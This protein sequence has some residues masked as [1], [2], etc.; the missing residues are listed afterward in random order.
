M[1]IEK[2]AL[3]VEESSD[4]DETSREATPPLEDLKP[5]NE[6]ATESVQETLSLIPVPAE[7]GTNQS[8]VQAIKLPPAPDPLIELVSGTSTPITTPPPIDITD[9][10]N[11]IIDIDDSIQELI[12]LTDDLE[13]RRDQK[14]GKSF[15]LSL[16]ITS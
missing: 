14:R 6:K 10:K 3:L 4:E 16:F 12:D 15:Y 5:K 9:G 2:S 7:I 11:Q 13:E 1:A 8:A